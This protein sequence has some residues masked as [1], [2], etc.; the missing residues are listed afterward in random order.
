[1]VKHRP[2]SAKNAAVLHALRHLSKQERDV[3]LR[4][5][6]DNSLTKCICECVLNTINGNIDVNKSQKQLLRKHSKILRK[7]ADSRGTWNS[8]RKLI[9]QKGG[10]LG[11]LL[12]VVGSI[13]AGVIAGAR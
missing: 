5:L 2:I 10:F 11:T 12:S 3:I 4:K 8:K 13:L 7:L 6:L 9:V 1:M